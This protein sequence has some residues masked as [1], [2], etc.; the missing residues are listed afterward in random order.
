MSDKVITKEELKSYF[1]HCRNK[2]SR[3]TIENLN[4]ESWNKDYK[5]GSIGLTYFELLLYNIRHVQHHTRTNRQNI[6]KTRL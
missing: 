4:E 2:C 1:K 3:T 5:Y 6:S